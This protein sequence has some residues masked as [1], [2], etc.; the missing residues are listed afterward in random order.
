MGGI[1]MLI[2]WG[3]LQGQNLVL[4]VNILSGVKQELLDM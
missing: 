1:I 3:E 4:R 2:F